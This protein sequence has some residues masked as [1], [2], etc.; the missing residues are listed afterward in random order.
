M[1]CFFAVLLLP[2]VDGFELLLSL[3]SVH[4]VSSA[5][6]IYSQQHRIFLGCFLL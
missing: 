3:G 1:S 6:D 4:H 2:V 5:A